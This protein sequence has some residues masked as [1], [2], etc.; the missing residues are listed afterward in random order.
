MIS[1]AAILEQLAAVQRQFTATFGRPL[2]AIVALARADLGRAGAPLPV[3]QAWSHIL[4]GFSDGFVGHSQSDALSRCAPSPPHLPPPMQRFMEGVR[5]GSIRALGKL[6][7]RATELARHFHDGLREA[8]PEGRDQEVQA[9]HLL[10]RTWGKHALADADAFTAQAVER[11]SLGGRA[12]GARLRVDWLMAEVAGLSRSV[13]EVSLHRRDVPAYLVTYGWL[14][15][16]LERL[17]A[18]E[19]EL[20]ETLRANLSSIVHAAF[21][22]DDALYA[23]ASLGKVR[24][25][26]AEVGRAAG[27]LA[28]DPELAAALRENAPTIINRAVHGDRWRYAAEV[29]EALPA[30]RASL[31]RG[32]ERLS[33]DERTARAAASLEANRGTAISRAIQREQLGYVDVIVEQLPGVLASLDAAIAS[34][35]EASPERAEFLAANQKYVLYLAIQTGQF[36]TCVATFMRRFA[37]RLGSRTT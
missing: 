24:A 2:P 6:S 36:R 32:V 13:L 22:Q 15:G 27:D 10:A 4:D 29:L 17:P 23:S 16:A 28:A 12:V 25:L 34:C 9:L 33:R 11:S 26:H 1:A 19:R 14:G 8:F 20:A 3:V 37:R 35:R 5:A 31:D 30:M 21:R 7:P 18:E